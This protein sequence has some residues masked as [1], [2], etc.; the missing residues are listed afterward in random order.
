MREPLQIWLEAQGTASISRIIGLALAVLRPAVVDD[1]I[2]VAD[3]MK[4]NL[5]HLDRGA[6]D[7]S[8]VDIAA[9]GLC[10]VRISSVETGGAKN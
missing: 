5:I 3:T 4:S 9:V 1:H 8:F 7:L 2:V 6:E 10:F